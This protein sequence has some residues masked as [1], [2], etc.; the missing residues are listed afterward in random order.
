MEVKACVYEVTDQP[1][2]QLRTYF[3]SFGWDLDPFEKTQQIRFRQFFPRYIM[4]SDPQ[5][6]YVV[7][8]PLLSCTTRSFHEEMAQTEDRYLG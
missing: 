5:V 2:E 8:R 7:G 1:V 6:T 3:R 4:P